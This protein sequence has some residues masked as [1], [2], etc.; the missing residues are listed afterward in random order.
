MTVLICLVAFVASLLT[1]F[2]GFGLGTIL[3]PAFA[4]FFPLPLAITM[5]ALVHLVNTLFK[6]AIM[7]KY[8]AK[9]L[10]LRF[11]IPALVFSFVGALLFT[12]S[13][14]LGWIT[15]YSLGDH[16]FEI[17]WIKLI[18]ATVILVFT[19]L[20]LIPATRF[21]KFEPKWISWGGALSG[22]FGGLSGHQ[23]ALRS[24]FLATLNLSKENFIG[25]SAVIALLIDL[26]RIPVY[27]NSLLETNGSLHWPLLCLVTLSA[28]GGTW[29]GRRYLKKT[30]M[31]TV[32]FFVGICLIV[33]SI[34]LGAGLI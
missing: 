6:I 20:E 24:M 30:T 12:H 5:T 8:A 4:I 7:G 10:V 16:H 19:L 31:K 33:F 34:A 2:S 13:A 21:F 25:S 9:D 26:A 29:I 28:L 23:G 32:Q 18:L 17:T 15:Q 1:F 22:F 3:L 27:S 14:G 11:G